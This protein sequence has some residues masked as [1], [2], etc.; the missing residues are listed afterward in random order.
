M[1]TKE[2]LQ[3]YHAAWYL[4]NK[5]RVDARNKQWKEANPDRQ[6]EFAAKSYQANKEKVL[7]RAKT[8]DKGRL[9]EY[10]ADY[11]QKNKATIAASRRQRYPEQAAKQKEQLAHSDMIGPTEA[12]KIL[13]VPLRRFRRWVYEGKIPATKSPGGRYLL[14]R[15]NIEAMNNA[16]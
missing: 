10:Q 14:N 12:A 13:G 1:R 8:R 15:K 7:A 16:I 3:A 5:A 4:R 9:K 6:K 11:F 2:E